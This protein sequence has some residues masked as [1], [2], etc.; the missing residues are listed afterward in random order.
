M[1]IILAGCRVLLKLL[2]HVKAEKDE[3]SDQRR[4]AGLIRASP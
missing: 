3:K 2:F 1:A 4:R